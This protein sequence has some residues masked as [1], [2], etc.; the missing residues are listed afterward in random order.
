MVVSGT[1][2]NA[3]NTLFAENQA[4]TARDFS[5]NFTTASHNF[6]EVGAGSNLAPGN[7][8]AT[9]NIVG[10]IA[11]PIQP[12]LGSLANNGGPTQTM[13]LLAGSLCV[14]A[15]T[16]TGAPATDQRGVARDTPPDIGAFELE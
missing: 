10:T 9:G 16:S 6:L 8:D 7:P 3:I 14:N 11:Q 13:A 12:L 4:G 1:V 5:G 15:G 2:V